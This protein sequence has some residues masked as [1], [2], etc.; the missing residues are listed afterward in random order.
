MLV[1]GTPSYELIY[2]RNILDCIFYVSCLCSWFASKDKPSWRDKSL[3]V[4]LITESASRPLSGFWRIDDDTIKGLMKSIR[5][6]QVV[7]MQR[8]M[9]TQ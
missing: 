8:S 4:Q 5:C 2:I 6:G 1:C 3:H 9:I 7:I